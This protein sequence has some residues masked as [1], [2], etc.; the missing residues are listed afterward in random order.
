MRKQ[1]VLAINIGNSNIRFGIFR[2]SKLITSD[3]I[4]THPLK[5]EK[6]ITGFI[7]NLLNSKNISFQEIQGIAIAS[8]VPQYNKLFQQ[9]IKEIL[10]KEPLFIS[11]ELDLGIRLGVDNPQ[12]IGADILADVV[13]ARNVM[14]GSM[15]VIDFG[16]ATTFNAVNKK[17][18]YIGTS[19]APGVQMVHD[20][21][22]TKTALLHSVE[23]S[24]QSFSIGTNT[25]TAIQSGV[26]FGYVGLVEGM[27]SRFKKQLGKEAKVIVTGGAAGFIVPHVKEISVIPNLTL[28]G[29]R[30][31]W[32]RDK[33]SA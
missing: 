12:Q 19:I 22:I 6:Y 20:A 21:L 14:K 31:I 15:I 1:I 11:S 30:I 32:G 10:H 17:G 4:S 28:D 8:V 18:E 2:G 24:V 7:T 27:I 25:A 9:I 26:L 5:T 23:L 3:S 16:T 33:S 13:A 29:I